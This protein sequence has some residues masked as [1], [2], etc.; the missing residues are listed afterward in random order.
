VNG[1][2]LPQFFY[3]FDPNIAIG[4][5]IGLFAGAIVFTW[6]FNSTN[7]SVLMVALFH[8]CFDFV[9]AANIHNDFPAVVVSVVVMVWAL[10]VIVHYK[11]KNLSTHKRVCDN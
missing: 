7:G 5:V 9:S 6:I 3:L 11:P 1:K 2:F 8:G 10:V 4:W